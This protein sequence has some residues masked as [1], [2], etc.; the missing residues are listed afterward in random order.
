[1]M[2]D[3]LGCTLP[4]GIAMGYLVVFL[5]II[6]IVGL[7]LWDRGVKRSRISQR[8]DMSDEDFLRMFEDTLF[9]QTDILELRSILAHEL[10]LPVLKIYPEDELLELRDR[11]CEASIGDVAL[12]DALDDLVLMLKKAGLTGSAVETRVAAVSTIKD[13]IDEALGARSSAH[14]IDA[15]NKPGSEGCRDGEEIVS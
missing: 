15:R 1:M 4:P 14:G 13:Y 5:P 11:Y 9:E 3:W 10:T 8:E 7:L 12:G 6:L 2:L